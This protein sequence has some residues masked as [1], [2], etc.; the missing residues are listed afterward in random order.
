M[1]NIASVRQSRPV[2]QLADAMLLLVAV[3]WG[4]SYAATKQALV[5]YPVLDFIALRFTL[6][7]LVLLPQ[8]R[9]AAG[10]PRSAAGA[11]S[12]GRIYLRDAG[13]GHYQHR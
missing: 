10:A 12:A 2:L 8:L 5:Y 6:T 13:R 1:Q 4:R 9:G 7:F 11:N 3:I